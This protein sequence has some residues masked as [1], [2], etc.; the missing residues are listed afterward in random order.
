M[1]ALG[2]HAGPILALALALLLPALGASSR[3]ALAATATPRGSAPAAAPPSPAPAAPA[4]GSAATR[5]TTKNATDAEIES[6]RRELESLK[7]QLDQRHEISK[8]LKGKEKDVL[9]QLRDSDRNLQLTQR[10]LNALERRRRVVTSNLGDATVELARTSLQLDA[11]RRRLS[12]RLREMYKRGRSADLE[13]VLSAQSFGD[14]VTRTYYLARIAQEDR[15]QMLLTQARRGQVQDTK[16]RLESRQRELDRL[17]KETDRERQSLSQ[18]R[19]ERRALLQKVRTDAKSNDAAAKQ[20]EDASRR[21]QALIGQ[22]EKQRLAAERG[23]PGTQP[24]PLLG[25][26]GRNKGRLPWPVTGRV[27]RSFGTQTN[28][29]FGTTTF[30]SGIDVAAASGTPFSAVAKGQVA[31]VNVLEGYGKCVII[32]H[33][34]GF[35]T[36]YANA[37]DI[38]VTVGKEVAAGDVIGHVG[39]TGTTLGTALHFEIRKGREALNPLDWFR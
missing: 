26:F 38:L 6:N 9:A 12:W 3:H 15:A 28:P 29:R 11:D 1:A 20:L 24:L 31:Y 7:Q 33:G 16:A 37:S 25:D 21:I 10:Y 30:N 19:A 32:N 23:A 4:P 39:D 14:L 17:K 8:Q 35:Y 5:D 34:G 27:A 22:L 2:R 13:Y 18:L 36:L